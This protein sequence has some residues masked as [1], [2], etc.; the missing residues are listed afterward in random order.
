MYHGEVLAQINRVMYRLPQVGR[1]AYNKLTTYLEKCG[2]V[3][4]SFTPGIFKQATRPVYVCLV[5]DDF[6]VKY[7]NCDNAEHL[8]HHLSTEYK[9]TVD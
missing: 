6:F 4:T 2:C 1:I 7:V 5:V 8:I 9:C 3:S